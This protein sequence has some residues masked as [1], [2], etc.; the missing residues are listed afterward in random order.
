MYGSDFIPT[1]RRVSQAFLDIALGTTVYIVNDTWDLSSAIR[2]GGFIAREVFLQDAHSRHEVLANA[3]EGAVMGIVV[4][5]SG[6]GSSAVAANAGRS[7]D[8][9]KRLTHLDTRQQSRQHAYLLELL[10]TVD[11]CKGFVVIMASDR[12]DAWKQNGIM[13]TIANQK[14]Q[15]IVSDFHRCVLC[16]TDSRCRTLRIATILPVD[17]SAL[18]RD[19]ISTCPGKLWRS[20]RK[21]GKQR[22]LTKGGDDNSSQL[23]EDSA[24]NL[25]HERC[26]LLFSISWRRT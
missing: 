22:A 7:R 15:F 26:F 11:S 19:H 21:K 20:S 23:S 24:D 10:S 16:D 1:Q 8:K 4:V 13:S 3:T 17:S 9:K 2:A 5:L 18:H 6:P 12:N 14:L 25:W